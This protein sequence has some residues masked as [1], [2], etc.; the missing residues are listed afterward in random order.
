MAQRNG[1]PEQILSPEEEERL[2]GRD[3]LNI[4]EAT[5]LAVLSSGGKRIDDAGLASP[6]WRRYFSMLLEHVSDGSLKSPDREQMYGPSPK[7]IG[8]IMVE[9]ESLQKLFS[10]KGWFWPLREL[11]SMDTTPAVAASA[12]KTPTDQTSSSRWPWGNHDTE[13]LQHLAAAGE[14]WEKRYDPTFPATAPTKDDIEQFLEQRGVAKR[15]RQVMAQILR[16]DGLPHGP[17]VNR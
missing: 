6:E 17:R 8:A 15:V 11:A 16:A 12:Q 14:V 7:V 9:A 13:L 3:Y 4:G 1:R 5:D 2:L 10:R